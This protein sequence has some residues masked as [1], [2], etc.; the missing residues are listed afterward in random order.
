MDP[1]ALVVLFLGHIP[2]LEM[3]FFFIVLK[4]RVFS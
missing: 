3:G 1:M 4:S 2:V